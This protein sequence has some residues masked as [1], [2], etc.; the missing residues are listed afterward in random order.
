MIF[1]EFVRGVPLITVLF[2]ANTMLPLFLPADMTVDRLARPLIGVALF[3][4]AYMAE[5]VRGGLQAMPKGQYE[6]AMSLGLNYWQMMVFIILPQAL[7]IVIPDIVNTFIGLFKD[8]TLVSIVG[9]FDLL[10][11]IEA[12]RIDPQLG[13]A[14]HQL[15]GLCL[16]GLLLL[17]LLLRHVALFPRGRASACGRP[18]QVSSMATTLTSRQAAIDP[19]ARAGDRA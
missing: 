11:T 10:K 17:R 6:G 3:A 18:K 13:G 5:V 2:M 15:H 8:T 1:I 19:T 9:I 12:S 7:R 4:S 16:R 14:D